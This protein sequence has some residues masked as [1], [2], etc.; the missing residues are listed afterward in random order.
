MHD[1]IAQSARTLENFA[2]SSGQDVGGAAIYPNYALGDTPLEKLYG[3][4]VERLRE[5][6]RRIGEI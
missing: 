1:A 5:I 2:V 3:A 6:K 4:N